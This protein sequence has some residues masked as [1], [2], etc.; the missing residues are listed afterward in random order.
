[1]GKYMGI[2][3]FCEEEAHIDFNWHVM[4]VGVGPFWGHDGLGGKLEIT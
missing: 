1:M 4:Y 2:L 3:T